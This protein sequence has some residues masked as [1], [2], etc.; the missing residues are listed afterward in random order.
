MSFYLLC[1]MTPRYC[2]SAEFKYHQLI[3]KSTAQ[4]QKKMNG[5]DRKSA[6]VNSSKQYVKT[7]VIIGDA[8]SNYVVNTLK[9]HKQNTQ[10]NKIGLIQG[11]IKVLMGIFY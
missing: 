10:I 6:L 8:N 4:R 9:N 11:P 5:N 7:S 2:M 1:G 3:T